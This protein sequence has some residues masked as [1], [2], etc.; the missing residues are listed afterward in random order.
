VNLF[1]KTFY[2]V[3]MQVVLPEQVLPARI[4]LN[5]ELQMSDD[6]YFAF[7]MANPDLRL[8]RTAQ[9]E[10]IIVP[11]AGAESDYA[12]VE[13]IGQL[14][15]WAKRDGRGK[16]FGMSVEFILSTGAALSPNA[17]WVSNDRLSKLS[18]EQ[19][20]KFSHLIPEFVIEVMSPSDRLKAA[21]EKM[22]EWIRGSVDLAWLIHSDEKTVYVYRAGQNEAELR[23]GIVKLACEGPAAGFELD[24][25][26]IWAGL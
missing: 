5:P 3:N 22:Q 6:D 8:E 13:V 14:R 4:A 2:P 18:R 19:L 11:P 7:C 16:V 12:S 1:V 17:A 23:T 10:I 25:T 9:G 21:M 20:R 24:L 15:E 26:S